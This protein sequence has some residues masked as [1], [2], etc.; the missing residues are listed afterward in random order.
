[1]A[2]LMKTPP[3]FFGSNASG[4]LRNRLDGAASET[5]TLPA[6]HPADIVGSGAMALAMLALMFVFDR[7]RGAAC[8]LASK[9]V[10]GI[11]RKNL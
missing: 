11:S 2:H 9:A 3:G 6:H 5:G 1:M 8:L 10:P 7:R 4:L